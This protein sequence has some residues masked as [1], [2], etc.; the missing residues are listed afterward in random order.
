MTVMNS[1]KDATDLTLVFTTEFASTP[2]RV[3]NVWEDPRLLEKWWG[4]YDYPATFVRHEFVEGGESRYYMTGPEGQI[5]PGWWH[6]ETIDKPRY[7]AFANGIAGEDGEPHPEI[8]PMAASMS[9]EAIDSG[10]RMTV[11]S[12]FASTEQMERYLG[13]GME[14]GMGQALSQIDALLAD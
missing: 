12:Q 1:T 13:M 11:T 4:P 10:T 5:A 2:E 14:Q 9:L 7:L 6:I 8:G 3:W